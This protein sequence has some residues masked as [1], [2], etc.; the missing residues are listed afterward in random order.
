MSGTLKSPCTR[1]RWNRYGR[2]RCNTVDDDD[3]DHMKVVELYNPE[4]E[5]DEDDDDDDEKDPDF[6]DWLPSPKRI[7]AAEIDDASSTFDIASNKTSKEVSIHRI[8]AGNGS[9]SEEAYKS[10]PRRY[11]ASVHAETAQEGTLTCQDLNDA[12]LDDGS[13]VTMTLHGISHRRPR[14]SPL[15]SSGTFVGDR[16][17][18]I[19]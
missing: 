19:L 4:K 15:C 6:E 16:A 13:G 17:C 10:A 12:P 14:R 5:D 2:R 9:R 18:I 1:R 7:C 3:Y 8:A 11:S